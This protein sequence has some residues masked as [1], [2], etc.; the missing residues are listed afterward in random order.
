MARHPTA[1]R[2]RAYPDTT[3]AHRIDNGIGERKSPV[4]H[5]AADPGE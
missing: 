5:G 3:R 1:A 2:F 4:R